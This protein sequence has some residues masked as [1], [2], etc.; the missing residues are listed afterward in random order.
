M[1]PKSAL[2]TGGSHGAASSEAGPLPQPRHSDRQEHLHVHT[3]G[4]GPYTHSHMRAVMSQWQGHSVSCSLFPRPGA[5][6]ARQTVHGGAPAGSGRGQQRWDARGQ[7]SATGSQSLQ[8]PMEPFP[9]AWDRSEQ[10]LSTQAPQMP[11]PGGTTEEW[12]AGSLPGPAPPHP[13]TYLLSARSVL[14]PTSMMMTSLPLSVLTSS[15]H[16]EVCWKE[17]RSGRSKWG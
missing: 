8:C 9:D 12:T 2:C 3:Q 10:A 4:P 14:L 13:R 11:C 16:L 17:L 5:W 15:I 6:S 1:A 7:V